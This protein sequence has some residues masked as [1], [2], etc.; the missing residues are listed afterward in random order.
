MKTQIDRLNFQIKQWCLLAGY[1]WILFLIAHRVYIVYLYLY[2]YH[3]YIGHNFKKYGIYNNTNHY[4]GMNG[5][6]WKL[7]SAL[8]LTNT[9]KVMGCMYLQM[10]KYKSKTNS[11][12][13][14]CVD[15][16][17]SR[18]KSPYLY[19]RHIYKKLISIY[20]YA[21]LRSKNT[22]KTDVKVTIF[23][24]RAGEKKETYRYRFPFYA[25]T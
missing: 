5:I 17:L 1:S 22:Q 11:L 9:I 12:S 10:I 23:K 21:L 19:I 6:F 15:I 8:L 7:Q 24:C 25:H 16:I 2:E 4:T 20:M 13:I 18:I 14:D 3:V